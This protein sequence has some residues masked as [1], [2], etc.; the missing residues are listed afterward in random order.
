MAPHHPHTTASHIAEGIPSTLLLKED[1]L[2]K[3]M[4]FTKVLSICLSLRAGD[5]NLLCLLTSDSFHGNGS[6]W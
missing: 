6:I 4:M 2:L 1:L 5:S 3:G